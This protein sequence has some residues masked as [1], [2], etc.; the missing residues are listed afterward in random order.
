MPNIQGFLWLDFQE[1]PQV[2]LGN[3]KSGRIAGGAN[4]DL[5][6]VTG[7]GG[8]R[9]GGEGGA[10]VA[11]IPLCLKKVLR[12]KCFISLMEMWLAGRGQ[13]KRPGG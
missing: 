7:K 13:E 4:S 11:V 2:S 8:G 6:K 1:F 10:A 9:G 3:R 5:G 12:G